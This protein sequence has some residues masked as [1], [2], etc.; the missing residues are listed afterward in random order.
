[1]S[2]LWTPGDDELSVV[3]DP[4]P[5]PGGGDPADEAAL[6]EELRR[7]RAEIA[8]TPAVDIVANHAI[9]LW[10]LAVLHLSPEAGQSLRLSEAAVAI[11]AMGGLVDALGERL[12]EHAEPLR[13]AVTQLR[14]A[15]VEVQ[16]Q[17]AGEGAAG[18]SGPPE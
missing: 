12:G 18:P 4:G 15:F 13:G 9:G 10:Q 5:G 7:V 16:R 17:A 14:L 11:D 3:G 8:S 6:E 2:G 1:M